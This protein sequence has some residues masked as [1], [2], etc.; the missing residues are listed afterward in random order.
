M[1]YNAQFFDVIRY[2]NKPVTLADG[3]PIKA[4][5]IGDGYLSGIV[6][7]EVQRVKL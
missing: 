4:T 6:K 2:L 3:S 7:N 1:T 5:G